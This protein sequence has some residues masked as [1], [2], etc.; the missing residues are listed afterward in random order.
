MAESS[1]QKGARKLKERSPN[2]LVLHFGILRSFSRNE[3]RV[4][5]HIES[6]KDNLVERC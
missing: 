4:Y 5:M 3:Q 6:E 1:R 2:V